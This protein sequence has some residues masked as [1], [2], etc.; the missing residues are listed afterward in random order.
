MTGGGICSINQTHD[1]TKN[2]VFPPCLHNHIFLLFTVL[3]LIRSTVTGSGLIS[4]LIPLDL[5]VVPGELDELLAVV[6]ELLVHE[7][8]QKCA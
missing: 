2:Y 7:L 3:L 1:G 5:D 6:E 4:R 8:D